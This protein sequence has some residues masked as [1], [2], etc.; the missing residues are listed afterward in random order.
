MSIGLFRPDVRSAASGI[1]AAK[2]FRP[3]LFSKSNGHD[4]YTRRYKT[5]AAF[6]WKKYSGFL[7]I[8]STGQD[9]WNARPG[10]RLERVIRRG[11]RKRRSSSKHFIKR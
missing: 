10:R 6:S 8:C 3:F 7:V 5:E 9:V 2:A 11:D 4:D 1:E